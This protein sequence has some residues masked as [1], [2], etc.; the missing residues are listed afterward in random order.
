MNSLPER[1]PATIW[2][3]AVCLVALLVASAAGGAA[4]RP[5]DSSLQLS[6]APVRL[7]FPPDSPDW[8]LRLAAYADAA[9]TGIQEILQQPIAAATLRWQ[10]P[11][12]STPASTWVALEVDKAKSISATLTE[13]FDTL[14]S[15][16]GTG[17]A[18]GQARWLAGYSI[19]KLALATSDSPQPWWVEGAALYLTDLLAR[20]ERATTPILY[21]LQAAYDRASQR[22]RPVALEDAAG[23]QPPM[24]AARGK[25][26]AT[27]KLLE[28]VYGQVATEQTIVTLGH[29][30]EPRMGV[31]DL[32]AALQVNDGPDAASLLGTWLTP[33]PTFDLKFKR[34]RLRDGGRMLDLQII[35][36]A[37]LAI[38]TV[39]EIR[40]DDDNIE[41]LDLN[42]VPG[43]QRFEAPLSCI[44][45]EVRLDPDGL[46]PDS[47]RADNRHGFGNA[48]NIQRFFVFDE[49]F[50]I[51]ELDF[52][53]GIDVESGER[54][55]S[56]ELAV[57]NRLGQ[58]RGL[59]V[60]VSAE[61]LDRPE[62][63]QRAYY[64][65][66]GPNESR[67]LSESLAYPRR[68][69][70]R[71]RVEARYWES[72]SVDDLTDKLISE[73]PGLTNAYIVV[74][75]APPVPR[76][77][78]PT[79]L[80]PPPRITEVSGRP[81][82][83]PVATPAEASGEPAS[84]GSSP[85]QL[86]V[87]LL[88]PRSDTVPIGD[89]VLEASVQTVDSSVQRV[90]FYVNDRRIGTVSSPPYRFDWS[91]PEQEQ[92]FV[93]RAVT[94]DN[95]GRLATDVRVLDRTGLGFGSTVDLVTVHATVRELGGRYVRNL[96]ASEF[97][98]LEDD[99][100]QE[101]VQF[102]YGE[103]P[104]TTAV[105]MDT[106]SS[107]MGGGITAERAGA[108]RLVRSLV[109][110]A[111]RA[112]ILGFNSRLHLYSSFINDVD[113]LLAAIET[114][115]PDGSTALY[116]GLAGALRKT[117]RARG[118]RALVMLS[119]GLDTNSVFAYDDVLEYARQADVLVYTIGLQLMHEG[120]A[121][122]DASGA[123]RRG[124]SS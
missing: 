108:T 28:G 75:E 84:S 105:L 95:A 118:K 81:E 29:L 87:R 54:R 30:T 92:R 117:N 50:E 111:N 72:A 4:P 82:P 116:D 53:G 79:G 119:D 56:F 40:C 38:P 55:E 35:N 14:A 85:Q 67:V 86:G 106:S 33:D 46:L 110:G 24:T 58:A 88:S 23:L 31:D 16:Y 49:S 68:G 70:G 11:S 9:A 2:R 10:L 17:Y 69:N 39:L 47:N 93:I 80:R 76:R 102:D 90:D 113:A 57:T 44:P 25:A 41:R 78:R 74:R 13:S 71:A 121:L 43:E 89:I 62:R 37:E 122:G 115:I 63:T 103:I 22:R 104:I 91:F 1:S 97:V 61:W 51:G 109:G 19:A 5:Q 83:T 8:G 52:K 98:I 26:Y 48:D 112:M 77:T 42:L 59:G 64:I 15:D 94:I 99:V 27:F 107:M 65:H 45:S 96:E 60:L 73:D 36:E 66:L 100:A 12:G 6:A 18:F 120:T 34:V 20:R 123:V 21:G 7:E 32:V 114:T 3:T 101:I 124:S